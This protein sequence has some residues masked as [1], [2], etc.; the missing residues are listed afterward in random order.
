MP[1]QGYGP[2]QHHHG[3]H[4][5]T[6]QG[7]AQPGQGSQPPPEPYAPRP[8]DY[9][10]SPDHGRP[11]GGRTDSYDQPPGRRDADHSQPPDQRDGDHSQ[12]PPDQGD[13]DHE[14]PLGRTGH[15]APR[16]QSAH[17]PS[18]AQTG[19]G[20]PMGG[21]GYGPPPGPT[22]Y[23]P[24][25]GQPSWG[26]PSGQPSYGPQPGQPGYGP[27]PG[28]AGYGPQPGQQPSYSP[29]V[30]PGPPGPSAPPHAYPSAPPYPRP[31]A[32]KNN[33]ALV[34]GLV[35]GLTALLLAGGIGAYVFLYL[36][37]QTSAT[38]AQPPTPAPTTPQQSNEPSSAPTPSA[39]SE[40]TTTP[41]D[42]EPT[43]KHADPGSPLTA[44][45]FEDWNFG[46]GDVKYRANK[47]GGWTYDTCD[48]VDGTGVLAKNDCQ[49]AIQLAYT[50]YSGHLKAIQIMMSFPSEQ[51]AKTAATSLAR[52]S[53]G[54]KWKKD[55][56]L[57]TYVYGKMQ[58]GASK[59][60][61]VVTIVT[62]DKTAK[63]EATNF[64]AYLQADHASYFLLRD[65]TITS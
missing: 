54:V 19:Y 16:D 21:P 28:Q 55:K 24:P 45:E 62:A 10:Q 52:G 42:P 13:G 47:V 26:P 9:G 25:S 32:R 20:P 65:L 59:K 37:Q 57:S 61:V 1:P 18:P 35:V 6:P 17:G 56:A 60:Y 41:T 3:S 2:P 38:I 22:S 51:A 12:S 36:P 48:P 8:S 34:I 63:T 33:N 50:A 11:P 30:P 23:G 27:L 58:S 44:G 14:P 39:S 46:L 15:E 7:H 5:G 49:R 64:H 40:P 31:P 29:P 43:T 53:D 4:P